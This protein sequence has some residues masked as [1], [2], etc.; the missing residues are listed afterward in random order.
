MFCSRERSDQGFCR[1]TL[2]LPRRQVNK[3]DQGTLFGRRFAPIDEMHVAIR[4]HAASLQLPP[5]IG[6]Q[7]LY[8]LD[9]PA[10]HA[11][12]ESETVRL[13]TSYESLTGVET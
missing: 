3:Q 13:A 11:C 4:V 7:N 9:L 10:Q 5:R 1:K 8:L 2:L 12:E 6:D